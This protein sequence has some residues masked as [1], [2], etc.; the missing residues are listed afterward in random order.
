MSTKNRPPE[1]MSSKKIRPFMWL[2]AMAHTDTQP[3]HF[4][5]IQTA[6]GIREP[7]RQTY[8]GNNKGWVL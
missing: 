6:A 2:D 3:T 1:I 8:G 7:L 5:A 4:P